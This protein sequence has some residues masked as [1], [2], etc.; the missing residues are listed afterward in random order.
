M[1]QPAPVEKAKRTGGKK[2]RSN[3]DLEQDEDQNDVR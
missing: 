1:S 3:E 2:K